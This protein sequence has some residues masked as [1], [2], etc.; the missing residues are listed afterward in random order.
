MNQLLIKSYK[1]A[2][3]CF[4]VVELLALKAALIV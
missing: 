2:E 1:I 3:N 4:I